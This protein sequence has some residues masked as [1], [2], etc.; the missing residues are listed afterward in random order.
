MASTA[1]VTG[2][3][4]ANG[5]AVFNETGADVDFRVESDTVDHALF[6]QGS[7]GF[8]GI[9]TSSPAV[10]LD[11]NGATNTQLRL[12]ASD[13]LGASIINFGDQANAA[14]GRII[15]SHVTDSFS[16]KTN[17]VNDR[18]GIDS[19]GNVLIGQDSGDAFNADAMLRLQK[20]GDRVFQSFKVDADQE[21]AIFFGDVDDDIECGISYEA[22]NQSLSFNTGNNSE[23]MRIDSSGDV[24]IG[25]G[26]PAAKLHIESAATNEAIRINT[27]TGYNAGINYYVSDTIKWTAQVLG[28]GTDAYRFYNFVS[29][30]AMRIDASGNVLVGTTT[31]GTKTGDGV[32]AFGAAGGVMS[33]FNVSVANNGTLDIAINTGGGGYQGFLL[34]SNTNVANAAVRTQ[35]TFSVFGRSTD[36]SIQQIATDTGPTS[37]ATFTVTTPSNGVIRVTNTSGSTTV[38]SMQFFGGTSG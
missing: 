26:A 14:Q 17:N 22:A 37:A 16:F 34:V 18:L 11:V 7:D 4:T 13:S 21:A 31:A 29:G 30:E 12:T 32:I 1:L 25:T 5:G 28:D 38:V 23:A 19:S 6:V 8:V 36:S 9:G 2:V 15:Y 20:T 33:N 27:S 24:G 3:L 10:A 35:S